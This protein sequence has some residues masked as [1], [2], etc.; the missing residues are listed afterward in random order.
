MNSSKSIYVKE[1]SIHIYIY[2]CGW[3]KHMNHVTKKNKKKGKK[4]K[5]IDDKNESKS[6]HACRLK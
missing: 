5:E 1:W 4:K 2:N 3:C 6:V